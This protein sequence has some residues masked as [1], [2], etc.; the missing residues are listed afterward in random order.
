MQLDAITMTK[1]AARAAFLEY[2]RAV[3]A[4]GSE[5]VA[6]EDLAIMRGYRE[7]VRGRQIINIRDAFLAGGFDQLRRPK[8]AL[9]RANAT[10]VLVHS[11]ADGDVAFFA[12]V[13]QSWNAHKA[14][15]RRF[16]GLATWPEPRFDR[17][18]GDRDRADRPAALPPDPRA[19][20]VRRAVGGRVAAARRAAR[21]RAPEAPRRRPLCGAGDLGSDR[22]RPRGHR[23]N[24]SSL[25]RIRMRS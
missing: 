16:R 18:R 7:I 11:D 2:R 6:A 19:R 1:P 23:R 9:A 3:R 4:A 15:I 21:S 25:M 14:D 12:D 8:L 24:A 13:R 17:G 5:R 10:T 20:R 22:P